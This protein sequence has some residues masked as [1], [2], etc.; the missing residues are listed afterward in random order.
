MS[1]VL[2]VGIRSASPTSARSTEWSTF[3]PVFLAQKQTGVYSEM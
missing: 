3:K 1:P 2:S